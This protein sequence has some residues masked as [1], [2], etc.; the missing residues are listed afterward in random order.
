MVDRANRVLW[1]ALAVLLLGSGVAGLL[2]SLGTWGRRIAEAPLLPAGAVQTI[3]PWNRF[4]VLAAVLVAGLLLAWL[5]WW[6]VR[7]QLRRGGGRSELPDLVLPAAR[8]E[9]GRNRPERPDRTPSYEDGAARGDIPGQAELT[10][11]RGPAIAKAVE[12]DL[13]R[14][15]G[16]RKALVGLYGHRDDVELRTQ[17]DIVN[18]IPVEQVRGNVRRSIDRFVRTTGIQ[19]RELDVTLR[20]VSREPAPRVR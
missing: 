7:L 8:G 15:P 4:V 12:R 5:G 16:V 14:L 9:S 20:I 3:S 11:V 13:S 17:L 18:D 2:A 1:T 10:L 6:L 19:P